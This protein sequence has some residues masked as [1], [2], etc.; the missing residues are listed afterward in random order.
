MPRFTQTRSPSTSPSASEKT[1]EVRLVPS[2]TFAQPRGRPSVKPTRANDLG[3]LHPL[4]PP[5]NLGKWIL[6]Y[7]FDKLVDVEVKRDEL[8]RHR[9]NESV[10]RRLVSARPTMPPSSIEM[11]EATG[12]TGQAEDGSVTT[13]RANG[14]NFPPLTPGLGIALATPMNH[15]LSSVVEPPT[16]PNPGVGEKQAP[17]AGRMSTE[18][19]DYFSSPAGTTDAAK[20]AA[21]EAQAQEGPKKEEVNGRSPATPFGKKFRM[22]MS[23]GGGKK[24]GRSGSTTAAERPAVVDERAEESEESSNHE[25]EVEDCF[26]GAIQRVRYEYDRQLTD[27]PEHF[28]GTR[29]APSLPSETPVLRL[30][31]ETKVIIQEETSGGSVEVYKGTIDTVGDDVDEIEHK[32]PQWLGE[33]LLTV[34]FFFLFSVVSQPQGVARLWSRE[35]NASGR[36]GKKKGRITNG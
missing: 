11:P 29:L 18:R 22:G 21:T 3:A 13:P 33:V 4:F 2:W 8:Y 7:L 5:V 27:D 25:R 6:R 30:P 14:T 24:L 17:Q 31:A 32:G 20:P 23:F 34:S 12:T 1:R 36:R 9:L 26:A 28:V 15:P 16:S 19:E 35:A 10:E